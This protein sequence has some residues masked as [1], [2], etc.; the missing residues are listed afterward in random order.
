VPLTTSGKKVKARF[1]KEY[2]KKKGEQYF[3]ATMNLHKN[4]ARKW[5]KKR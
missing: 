2:G 3:Y 5:H 1:T 4:L